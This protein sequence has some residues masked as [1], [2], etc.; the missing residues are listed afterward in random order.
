MGSVLVGAASG[1]VALPFFSGLAAAAGA[2]SALAAGLVAAAGFGA[3]PG[4][5]ARNVI[6]KAVSSYSQSPPLKVM[7]H[8]SLTVSKDFSMSAT[9]LSIASS[10]KAVILLAREDTG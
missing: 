7:P 9:M 10:S 5:D 2:A 8:R 3:A 1:S 4:T 6:E